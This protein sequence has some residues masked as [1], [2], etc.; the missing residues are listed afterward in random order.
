MRLITREICLRNDLGIHGNLFGGTMMSWLDKAG[1]IEA[2]RL[3]QSNKMVTA[4]MEGIKFI[5]KVRENQQV[6]IYGD[7]DSMG[8][9]SIVINLEARKYNVYTGEEKLVCKTRAIF[10]RID[11]EGE[12][13]PLGEG[14]KA[15]IEAILKNKENE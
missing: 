5:R 14:A 8:K 4:E 3:C 15:G 13:R 2:T 6:W 11:D 1:V 10:V 9:T 12:K 7:V